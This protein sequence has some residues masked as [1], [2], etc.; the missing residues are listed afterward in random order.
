MAPWDGCAMPKRKEECRNERAVLTE[1]KSSSTGRAAQ[2][3][4]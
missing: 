4:R 1:E 3:R 2:R